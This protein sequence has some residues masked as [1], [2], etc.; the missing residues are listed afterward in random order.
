MIPPRTYSSPSPPTNSMDNLIPLFPLGI[1]V[2]PQQTLPLHIFEER[3]KMMISDCAPECEGGS[4]SAFGISWEEEG[5]VAQAG[6]AV[7]VSK[8]VRHH[9]DGSFDIVTNATQRYRAIEVSEDEKPYQPARVEFFDDLEEGVE[10]HLE[11]T[12]RE[13][14]RTLVE[15][16]AREAGAQV[17]DTLEEGLED[18]SGGDAFTMAMRM[19][20][21]ARYKQ[22]MLEMES[23]NARLESLSGYLER[24]LPVLEQ[25]LERKHS[26]RSN[27][28]APN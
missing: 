1:V 25:R 5:E 6:C 16:A 17:P 20:L 22:E 28:K 15:L 19:G 24:L 10:P 11:A 21:E 23:E 13:R 8:I 14:F 2:F 12:V 26:A 9:S 3:Y 7:V 27:G 18:L 4:Y